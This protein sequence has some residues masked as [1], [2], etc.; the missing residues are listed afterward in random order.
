MYI[1]MCNA[2]CED[3]LK[4]V[5]NAHPDKKPKEIMDVLNISTGCG[6]CHNACLI[7]IDKLQ[8]N[9]FNNDGAEW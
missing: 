5:Y 7:Y 8:N 2:V 1:C 3:E 4:D 9:D 6:K